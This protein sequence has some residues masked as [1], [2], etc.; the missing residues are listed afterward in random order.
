MFVPLLAAPFEVLINVAWEEDLPLHDNFSGSGPDI[1]VKWQV[2]SDTRLGLLG[3][4]NKVKCCQEQPEHA[5]T[6][7]SFISV[8]FHSLLGKELKNYL[9]IFIFHSTSRYI[10]AL[11][12]FLEPLLPFSVML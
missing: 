2:E 7:T 12:T 10:I 1:L 3:D 9:C 4:Q 5:I 8:P 11:H 6:D